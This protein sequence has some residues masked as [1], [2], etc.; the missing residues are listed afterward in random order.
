MKSIAFGKFYDSGYDDRDFDGRW[1]FDC[2]LGTF[3]FGNQ[4]LQNIKYAAMPVSASSVVCYFVIYLRK[5]RE[6][7]N[8]YS[9]FI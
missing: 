4:E 3:H 5:L 1:L 7:L 8:F 2:K 6:C 9:K